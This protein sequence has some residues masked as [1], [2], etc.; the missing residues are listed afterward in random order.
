MPLANRSP[1]GPCAWD[2][3][4]IVP[5]TRWAETVDGAS[6]AYH[7]VGEGPRVLVLIN[8]WISHLEVYWEQP[9]FVR[10]VRRLS[11]NLRVLVFDKRGMGMSDRLGAGAD[12]EVRMDDVRA[13]M[14]AAKVDRAAMLGWGTGGA[15]L[16]FFFAATNP[17][18]T[19]AVCTDGNILEKRVA[20]YPWGQSEAEFEQE[21]AS[22]TA[23]WGLETGLP[24]ILADNTG[25]P[26]HMLEPEFYAWL[27]KFCRYAA[28]PKSLATFDRLWWETDV[29]DILGAVQAPTAVF[30]KT[31]A[32]ASWGN[33]GQAQ[34]LA[35]RVAAAQLLPIPGAAPNPWIEEPDP[36]VSAIER[37][38]G[39]VE[40]EEAAFDRVLA[41]VLFTDIVGSTERAVQ[42]GDSEWKRLLERHHAIV[43]ALLRR[44]RGEEVS[45]AGDG[46]FATFD[47]PGRAVRCAQAI[48]DAMQPLGIEIRAGLHTGELERMGDNVGGVAVHIGARIGALAGP[49]DVVVSSTVR[50]LVVGSGL[51]FAELGPHQLKGVDGEWRLYRAGPAR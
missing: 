9:R 41:T 38:L 15:P 35:D 33:R 11:R 42:L 32:P 25:G 17:E 43:R 2:A 23:A 39:S 37:F 24:E 19:L 49:S 27:A 30:Y 34:Y 5:E 4:G 45:T 36:L 50:D 29:R 26:G 10:F 12:L 3:V 20:G 48:V 44:Y 14:D 31:D 6:I 22:I 8:G 47:G 51:G 1:S 28:T 13:V 18:R 7:D 46:F 16:A 40:E 21:L